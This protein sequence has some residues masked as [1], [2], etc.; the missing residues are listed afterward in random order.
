[1]EI[2]LERTFLLKYK[3]DSLENLPSKEIIDVY[4]PQSAEHPVLR[5]RKKGERFELTKKQPKDGKDSSEQTEDTII[6]SKEEFEEFARLPGK[7][8]RKIR[9]Y[10]KFNGRIAEIDIYQDSLQGLCVV[11]VEFEKVEDKNNFGMP[12]FCL[13]DVTQDKSFAAGILAGKNYEDIEPVL[14][15]LG[16]KKI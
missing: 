16:Y 15:K 1:M 14:E 9:Y 8:L 7:Q 11:D 3:P 2:E 5:L 13:V 12:E 6:L 10:Y 4:F